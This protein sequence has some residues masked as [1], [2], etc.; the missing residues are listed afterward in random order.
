MCVVDTTENEG[1]ISGTID[2]CDW[3]P[4]VSTPPFIDYSPG[5][6]ESSVTFCQN[7]PCATG[8]TEVFGPSLALMP[9]IA[10]DQTLLCGIPTNASV[11]VVDGTGRTALPAF[12]P[13]TDL[14]ELSLSLLAPGIYRVVVTSSAGQRALPL[15]IAR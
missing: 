2:F 14:S 11:R 13:A 8:L 5:T 12:R 1:T 7:S 9:P 6:V 3:T 4:T 15:V 10:S